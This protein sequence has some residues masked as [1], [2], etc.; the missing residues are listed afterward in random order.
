MRL[1]LKNNLGREKIEPAK[2]VVSHM[3]TSTITKL[4]GA[5]VRG[6]RDYP[7]KDLP[8]D[9]QGMPNSCPLQCWVPASSKA[10]GHAF[11]TEMSSTLPESNSKFTPENSDPKGN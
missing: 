5:R 9:F 7:T 8:S 1:F 6:L 2:F 4:K 3:Q 10:P 11:Q